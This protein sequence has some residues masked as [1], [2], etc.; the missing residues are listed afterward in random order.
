MA[1]TYRADKQGNIRNEN[2]EIVLTLLAGKCSNKFKMKAA[3]LLANTLFNIERGEES[4][5][6]KEK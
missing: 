1:Q 4:R 3:K 6:Q 2:N 5:N